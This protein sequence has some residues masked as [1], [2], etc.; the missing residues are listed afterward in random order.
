[1]TLRRI[2]LWI[3]VPLLFAAAVVA[4]VLWWAL[5]TEGGARWMLHRIA[6]QVEGLSVETIGGTITD[7]LTVSGL[8]L[9]N[10]SVELVANSVELQL[11]PRRLLRRELYFASLDADT[12]QIST[13]Q[14]T[15][16]AST[17]T[18]IPRL[19]IDVVIADARIGQFTLRGAA[20]ETVSNISLA[21]AWRSN[22]LDIGG[23]Q[24]SVRGISFAAGGTLDSKN[25]AGIDIGV[26]WSTEQTGEW[27]G[28]GRIAGNMNRL[29][30][31]HR[32]AAP[33]HV[34]SIGTATIAGEPV[35]DLTSTSESIDYAAGDHNVNLRNARLGLSGTTGDYQVTFSA[36]LNGTGLPPTDLSVVGRGGLSGFD[37]DS[38]K[39]TP[40]RGA[41]SG[42]G[43][44]DW[45]Q[46][47][48]TELHFELTAVDPALFAPQWPGTVNGSVKLRAAVQDSLPAVQQLQLDLSGKIR[49]RALSLRGRASYSNDT[50]RLEDVTL[51]AGRSSISGNGSVLLTP[52]PQWQTSL[53]LRNV[54]PSLF[55]A[56]WPGRLN[57]TLA[58]SGS[59]GAAGPKL[60]FEGADI[61]GELRQHPLQ[62]AGSVRYG[63]GALELTGVRLKSGLNRVAIDGV[64]GDR[65]ALQYDVDVADFGSFAD[66]LGGSLIGHGS[67]GGSMAAPFIDVQLDGSGLQAPGYSLDRIS[68]NGRLVPSGPPSQLKVT[69]GGIEFGN[70]RVDRLD[71]TLNGRLQQH[72]I[73]LIAAV[74]DGAVTARFSGGWIGD[75]WRGE[76]RSSTIVIASPD[77][78]QQ[79]QPAE[80]TV[81][82]EHAKLA[83][84]CWQ[85]QAAQFC[86]GGIIDEHR[87]AL[88]ADARNVSLAPL[89][90]LLPP[91]ATLT[92]TASGS[93][94]ASGK[95]QNPELEFDVT[96]PGLR[97]DYS[98][99]DDED[100]LDT[101]LDQFKLSGNASPETIRARLVSNSNNNSRLL[102]D[103]QLDDWRND[104][105]IDARVNARLA[106]VG[107][108]SLFSTELTNWQGVMLAD[109]ALTGTP[110]NP[111]FSGFARLEDGSVAV[112]RTGITLQ[113]L[114]LDV[115]SA[116]GTR[117][118]ISGDAVSGGNI[119]LRGTLDLDRAAGWPVTASIS[120]EDFQ[121]I[122]LPDVA[123][124]VSPRLELAGASNALR[125]G[126]I[127]TIPRA[128]VQLRELP[129]QAVRISPDVR[130]VGEADDNIPSQVPL[131]LV[132]DLKLQLGEDVRFSGFGLRTG[133]AGSMQL[134]TGRNRPVDAQG[135]ITLTSGIFR[136]YGHDLE[137]S[138]GSLVFTG[139]LDNPT[140]DVTAT[141][142]IDEVTAGVQV[143]GTAQSPTSTVYAEPVM[144]EADA[145][146]YLV[147]GRPLDQASAAQGD[148]VRQAALQLGVAQS[149]AITNQI[150]RSIGLDELRLDSR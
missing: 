118:A 4:L 140:L 3:L 147:A 100:R 34:T 49:E 119:A 26:N 143:R 148:Q 16:G 141:R 31:Q 133:L 110:G 111:V 59:Y 44:I 1:M 39:I 89:A 9:V 27:S 33:F 139:P 73:E 102:I 79:E 146:A 53:R 74:N 47:L 62:L 113:Q 37:I 83:K 125:L 65:L 2:S 40:P 132:T 93:F 20:D 56:G 28:N 120:G 69:A 86:A 109:V 145:L 128:T 12:I 150:G 94:A 101:V 15:G 116:G 14:S 123:V 92:G 121:A 10:E 7:T 75:A 138:D 23:V 127:V 144:A 103:G 114:H 91:G 66:G 54:D 136:A 35:F 122:E 41:V 30:L 90:R 107:M 68:A 19:P 46:Q 36:D 108:L 96:A 5:S 50:V 48:R 63:M 84:V 80:L 18:H 98:Y 115:E 72:D 117:I 149:A 6:G 13:P 11:H 142:R 99:A 134:R 135:V 71:T 82:S 55:A 130:I 21:A 95:L 112:P 60:A 32:L 43:N 57:G 17:F 58:F 137:I 24:A 8:Q 105:R 52:Q 51:L 126:G 22:G 45:Q 70:Y 64:Y 131:Q 25:P 76:L 104:P 29:E 42:Y 129:Q 97:I 61:S 87:L 67:I 77:T 85:H 78:F 88:D 124:S 38:L 106:D 81:A